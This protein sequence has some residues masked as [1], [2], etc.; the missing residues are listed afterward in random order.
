MQPEQWK[1]YELLDLTAPGDSADSTFVL[2]AY[3]E[4]DA[5]TVVVAFFDGSGA[6][7]QAALITEDTILAQP[8]SGG[9]A[10]SLLSVGTTCR[11]PPSS[12]VNPQFDSPLA[13]SCLRSVLGFDPR[14]LRYQCLDLRS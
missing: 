4:S 1:G 3:R 6:P 9:G 2:L 5:H 12:L 10:T 13:S 11:T 8:S 7:Q 14:L